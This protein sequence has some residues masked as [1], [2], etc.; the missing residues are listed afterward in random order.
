MPPMSSFFTL[1]QAWRAASQ[2]QRN[3]LAKTLFDRVVI[4]DNRIVLVK[5]KPELKQFFK[6]NFEC[7]SRDIAGDPEGI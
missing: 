2:R 7:N 4:E 3:K 6:M 5:P 1:N